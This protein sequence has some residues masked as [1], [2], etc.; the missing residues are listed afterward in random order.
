MFVVISIHSFLVFSAVLPVIGEPTAAG[1]R[2]GSF[3][4]PWH[5]LT[6]ILA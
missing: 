1:V 3:R 4:L 2:T 5:F 6:S